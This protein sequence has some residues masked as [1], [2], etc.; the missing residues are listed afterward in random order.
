M[1]VSASA[2]GVNLDPHETVTVTMDHLPGAVLS[3]VDRRRSQPHFLRLTTDLPSEP[4]KLDCETE[5]IVGTGGEVLRAPGFVVE[6]PGCCSQELAHLVK[7]D[8]VTAN[9]S[10]E[11]NVVSMR[12]QF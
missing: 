10:H 9:P 8:L 7:T 2:L 11:R 12:P 5:R 1:A 6:C 4:L 3:P